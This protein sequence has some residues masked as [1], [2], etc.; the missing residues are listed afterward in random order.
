MLDRHINASF[1]LIGLKTVQKQALLTRSMKFTCHGHFSFRHFWR[2]AVLTRWN[3][4]RIY[5]Y[6]W[7]TVLATAFCKKMYGRFADLKRWP[8]KLEVTASG[9]ANGTSKNVGLGK[10]WKDLEISWAFLISLEV[11]FF[12]GWFLLFLSLETFHQRVSGSDF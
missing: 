9:V 11:S 3:C 4:K 10:F 6:E 12:H 8:K 7:V 2:V 1:F 5:S